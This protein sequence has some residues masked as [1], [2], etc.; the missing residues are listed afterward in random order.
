MTAFPLLAVPVMA[1]GEALRLLLDIRKL[2]SSKLPRVRHMGEFV[3][4]THPNLRK[5]TQLKFS[6]PSQLESVDV[7]FLAQPH[8]QAQQSFDQ[9]TKLATTRLL[10]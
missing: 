10:T 4:Q 2:K 1:G 9:Y 6:D 7:L 5:R 8:G 3:Y